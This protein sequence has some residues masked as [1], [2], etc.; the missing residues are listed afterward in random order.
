[1]QKGLRGLSRQGYQRVLK[2]FKVFH[3]FG[4][5]VGVLLMV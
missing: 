3:F 2:L 4:A 1:M 5:W